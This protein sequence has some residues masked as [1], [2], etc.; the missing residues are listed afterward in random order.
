MLPYQKCASATRQ[1]SWP[2]FAILEQRV[3]GAPEEIAGMAS[4]LAF[5]ILVPIAVM[6]CLVVLAAAFLVARIVW[7]LT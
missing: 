1:R 5:L 7:E 6:V 4:R 2:P 3:M